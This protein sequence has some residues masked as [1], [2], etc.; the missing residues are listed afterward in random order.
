[1]TTDSSPARDLRRAIADVYLVDH[2]PA[3]VH[4]APRLAALIHQPCDAEHGSDA[5]H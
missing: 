2:P 5:A 4:R 3:G 1:M